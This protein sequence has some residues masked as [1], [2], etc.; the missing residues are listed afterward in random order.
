M[1]PQSESNLQEQE[2]NNYNG[3]FQQNMRVSQIQ[4]QNNTQ[5]R[6]RFQPTISQP[7]SYS[8][9]RKTDYPQ[10]YM[11]SNSQA[12]QLAPTQDN[13]QQL[14]EKDFQEAYDDDDQIEGN[15]I[16]AKKDFKAF[17]LNKEL[18]CEIKTLHKMIKLSET[19]IQQLPGMISIKKEDQ[20]NDQDLNRV[21]VDLICLIDRSS[22]MRG[23]KMETVKS[24]L[25]VLLK[26]LTEK[27]RL[28]LITFNDNAHR[29]TPLRRTTENNKKQFITIVDK[30]YAQGGTQIASATE[31]AFQ[32]LKGRKYK[33]NVSSIFL[34]SDGQDNSA[35]QSIQKQLQ[36]IDEEFT[37]HSFGFG[38]DHDAAM[39]TSICN[40]KHG[41]FYFV[42]NI[43]LLD[44][45]FLDALG[46]LK[47]VVGEKL[48]VKVNLRP[49]EILKDLKISKTYGNMW[50]NKESHYEIDL[51]VLIEGQRKDF[52][53]EL[54]LPC[55]NAQ[56]QD[57]QRNP[58]IM[59]VQLQITDPL[60]K[61]KIQKFASLA[62][63]IFHQDEQINQNEED[64]EVLT[65]YNRVIAAQ[66]ID[67]ARKSC[68]QEKY[69]EAQN[70]LDDVLIK[71][72]ANQ[73][74][75]SQNPQLI[76]D[77]QQAKQASQK[78]TFSTYGYGQM[79]QL[80]SN[81]YQQQGVNSIFSSNGQQQQQNLRLS[82]FSNRLQTSMVNQ[83]QLR[84][85][86]EKQEL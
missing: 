35:T 20:T 61:D 24:S 51:P 60:T 40:L 14:K 23:Q 15:L 68:Q 70:K 26:Y 65:Q 5:T 74:F 78:Q 58:Q 77:L 57:N 84:K 71:F 37:I 19:K 29:L 54:E 75:S 11:N 56:I 62:L 48:Q 32:Q 34:L 1:L 7:L 38:E 73:Q 30:I 43:Y 79:I 80:S 72:Q 85:T 69:Q 13:Q 28:Q 25:K 45:F 55:S 50:I 36:S 47:S 64:I 2:K 9:R 10:Q 76:Q 66:V 3:Y 4:E 22:S 67:D 44:E 49:P 12:Q 31:I 41:S 82:S 63:T 59:E 81:S 18:I 39:M 33:N 86:Q 46:G 6:S 27:D 83:L 8:L 42:Q 21:G 52:V 16:L 53:F 17:D